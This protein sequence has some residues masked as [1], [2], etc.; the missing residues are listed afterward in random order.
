MSVGGATTGA[1]DPAFLHWIVAS[2]KTRAF[3]K[4]SV[5][6][7]DDVKILEWWRVGGPSRDK[8]KCSGTDTRKRGHLAVGF[9]RVAFRS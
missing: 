8:D 4:T 6:V 9:L 2:L 1:R 3:I 5:R 7:Q